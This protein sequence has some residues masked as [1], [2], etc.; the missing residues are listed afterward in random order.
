MRSRCNQWMTMDG[1]L[2][3]M[4]S[5]L[6][7]TVKKTLRQFGRGFPMSLLAVSAGLA[8]ATTDAAAEGRTRVAVKGVSA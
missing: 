7:G 3:T 8:A 2:A 5:P 1:R 6:T 4:Y